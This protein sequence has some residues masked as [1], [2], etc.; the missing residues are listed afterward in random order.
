M[1]VCTHAGGNVFALNWFVMFFHSFDLL[2]FVQSTFFAILGQERER[3]KEEGRERKEKGK[4]RMGKIATSKSREC[5]KNKTKS[6]KGEQNQKN[7]FYLSFA[8]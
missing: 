6:Q 3:E 5:L 1:C 4:E 2:S 8:F 7:I